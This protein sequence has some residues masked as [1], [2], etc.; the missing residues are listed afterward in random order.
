[1]G[2]DEFYPVGVESLNDKIALDSAP[3]GE[4]AASM[5]EDIG[6]APNPSTIQA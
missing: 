3:L 1:M 6:V 5:Y 4:Q 2:S